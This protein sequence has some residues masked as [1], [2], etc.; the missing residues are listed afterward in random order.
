MATITF[1]KPIDLADV[2]K[3]FFSQQPLGKLLTAEEIFLTLDGV[4]KP[5]PDYP[6]LSFRP[7]EF[8]EALDRLVASGEIMVRPNSHFVPKMW[9]R[10][11]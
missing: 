10:V 7:D 2:L 5:D 6:S 1:T 9:K 11:K 8:Y 3:K 4:S